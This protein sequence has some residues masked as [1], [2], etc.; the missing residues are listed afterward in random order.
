[1]S[2]VSFSLVG[3]DSFLYSSSLQEG[4]AFSEMDPGTRAEGQLFPSFMDQAGV[5]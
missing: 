4:T 3:L 5:F 1:M 2:G